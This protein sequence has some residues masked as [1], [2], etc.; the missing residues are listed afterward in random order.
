MSTRIGLACGYDSTQSVRDFARGIQ[1]ADERGFEIGF[2]SETIALMRD[3]VTAMAAFAISTTQIKLGCTQI[4]GLRSPVLMAETLA[5]LDELS[6]GRMVLCPGAAIR[7]HANKHGFPLT[8][9]AQTLREW[10]E[11]IRLVMTGEKVSYH[12][13]Y[14]NFD[15]VQMGWKPIRQRVPLWFAALSATGLRLAGELADGILLNTVASPEY[16]ENAIKIVREAAEKAGRDWN[17]FEVAQLINT[18]IEDDRDTAIDNVRWEVAYKFI[19]DDGSAQP[20][21]RRRVGEPHID[22][23]AL[24][25]IHD[26]YRTGG[27]PALER[28]LPAGMIAGLTASGT[29]DEVVSRVQDYRNAGVTLPIL[30]PAQR[31]QMAAILDLFAPRP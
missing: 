14:V 27:K 3:S 18:S 26:A 31:H 25:A 12:G 23:D 9:P 20:S 30:R 11:A 28:A 19:P 13:Q 24:P 1:F 15:D 5:T 7:I 8:E 29:P 4:V 17:G 10:V 6:G 16:A 22:P 2:F 21:Q